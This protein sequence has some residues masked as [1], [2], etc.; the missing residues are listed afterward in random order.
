MR[1]Y[2]KFP[3]TVP[4]NPDLK[5][6]LI[7]EDVSRVDADA[8][9]ISSQTHTLSP[10]EMIDDRSCVLEFESAP[11]VQPHHNIRCHVSDHTGGDIRQGDLISTIATTVGDQEQVKL[12]LTR[13]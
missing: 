9:L 10:A 2:L 1:I 12:T 7:V 8:L 6:K 11:S 13:V 5:V 4:D 3:D